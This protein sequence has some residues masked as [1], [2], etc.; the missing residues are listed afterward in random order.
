MLK[1]NVD[2]SASVVITDEARF[3]NRF[4][5]YVQH[6]VIKHKETYVQ[7]DIH[8]NTIEGFWSIVK[9]GI[10]GQYRVLS[11]R[12]LPFYLAEFAY[13]YNRRNHPKLIFEDF[14]KDAVSQQKCMAYEKPLIEPINITNN[15]TPE[16]RKLAAKNKIKADVLPIKKKRKNN[17]NEVPK[18][19]KTILDKINKLKQK[20][21]IA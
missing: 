16:Q 19:V 11:K 3:Y 10:K 9:G 20:K 4:D 17:L 5:D 7:G 1:R 15:V 6:L 14:M 2:T 18:S 13:R 12:Y 21:Q 8:T